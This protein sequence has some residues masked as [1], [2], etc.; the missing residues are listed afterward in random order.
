MVYKD[1]SSRVAELQ[2]EGTS[3][4]E[5]CTIARKEENELWDKW[6]AEIA[7]QGRHFHPRFP[8]S[9]KKGSTRYAINTAALKESDA[10]GERIP[11]CIYGNFIE[12]EDEVAEYEK[13]SGEKYNPAMDEEWV[14]RNKIL[15]GEVAKWH[16][17]ED[18]T[19]VIEELRNTH[20]SAR[21]ET[22]RK[23]P[24]KPYRMLYLTKDLG[25]PEQWI[26]ERERTEWERRV[27]RDFSRSKIYG[28]KS[29]WTVEY[30]DRIAFW[31]Y[32][33]MSIL[34]RSRGDNRNPDY[35]RWAERFWDVYHSNA[36]F[37]LDQE[38][39]YL[40]ENNIESPKKIRK[41]TGTSRV[42]IRKVQKYYNLNKNRADRNYGENWDRV[43]IAFCESEALSRNEEREEKLMPYTV[44]EA[45]E[46]VKKWW[47]WRPVL[48]ELK[49]LEG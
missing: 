9:W 5:A 49:R 43:L 36:D 3:W 6:E 47:G 16:T 40:T 37:P 33:G 14:K 13:S 28:V 31:Y 35:K 30:R 11:K 21:E 2:K 4:S 18:G 29:K 25:V 7:F 32:K 41:K 23:Q 34:K 8:R 20:E 17:L 24:L 27:L 22:V 39:L 46:S 1:F 48:N 38:S 15:R 42:L 44:K 12:F 19:V 10:Q 26:P 45:E